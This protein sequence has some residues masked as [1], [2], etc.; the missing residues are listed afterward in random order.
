MQMSIP[1]VLILDSRL[2]GGRLGKI[3]FLN[4][5]YT[6]FF[7]S[8]NILLFSVLCFEF[9]KLV[10]LVSL[11]RENQKKLLSSSSFYLF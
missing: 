3:R 8:S 2:A 6:T 9:I 1:N 4:L 7:P 5:L 10:P 11:L